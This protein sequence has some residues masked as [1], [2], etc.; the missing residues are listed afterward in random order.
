VPVAR[1]GAALAVAAGALAKVAFDVVLLS[2]LDEVAE[3]SPGGSS[4]MPHKRNPVSST[5]ARACAAQVHGHAAV[6]MRGEHELERAAGAWQAEWDALSSALAL[7]GGAAA[8]VREALEGLQV[9][10]VRLR[11]TMTP[12]LV[13]E[14]AAFALADEHGRE[15]A[16]RL[17]AAGLEGLELPAGVLD[18]ATYLGS[19]ET[20]VDR[21]LAR[22]EEEAT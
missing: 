19:A 5:L 11:A 16:H 21:A 10:E 6:L 1:L 18:P 3:G 22:Y 4:T 13:A 14:R 2:A 15:E 8:C 17:V 12:A 9:D 7:T 20:F